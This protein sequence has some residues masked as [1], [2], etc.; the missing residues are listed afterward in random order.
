MNLPATRYSSQALL[1]ALSLYPRLQVTQYMV[2]PSCRQLWQLLG[3]SIKR[4]FVVILYNHTYINH[5]WSLIRFFIPHCLWKKLLLP[6]MSSRQFCQFSAVR[7]SMGRGGITNISSGSR[8][9]VSILNMFFF[10]SV[11]R[12]SGRL[13]S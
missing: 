3:Q 13:D 2:P 10:M 4:R 9:P 11:L 1:L 6:E 7:G 8:K 12:R 5:W